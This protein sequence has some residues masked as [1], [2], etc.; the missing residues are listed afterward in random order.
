GTS[1]ARF[2]P[3]L[4]RV[5]ESSVAAILEDT[6]QAIEAG[7]AAPPNGAQPAAAAPGSAAKPTPSAPPASAAAAAPSTP[8]EIDL[9]QFLKTDLRVARVVEASL[10]DGA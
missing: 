6:R 4:Q 8:G 5:D 2:E 3:L 7:A 10:V 9:D 1:I